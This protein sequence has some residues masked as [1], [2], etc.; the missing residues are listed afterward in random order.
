MSA[1]G[2][3]N[4]YGCRVTG[5]RLGG[6]TTKLRSRHRMSTP[7]HSLVRTGPGTLSS[8]RWCPPSPRPLM[9]VRVSGSSAR[10]AVSAASASMPR[11]RSVDV[12]HDHTRRWPQ[13][14]SVGRVQRPVVVGPL[15]VGVRV[16]EAVA[17]QPAFALASA[18]LSAAARMRVVDRRVLGAGDERDDLET[19]SRSRRWRTPSC[20]RNSPAGGGGPPPFLLDALCALFTHRRDPLA[21]LVG[22]HAAPHRPCRGQ[23]VESALAAFPVLVSWCWGAVLV[24]PPG[25]PSSFMGYHHRH[26]GLLAADSARTARPVSAPDHCSAAVLG[27]PIRERGHECLS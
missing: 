21:Q 25:R 15:G 26:G 3:R 19:R 11:R 2:S 12:E 23:A 10:P 6:A 24:V 22:D 20:R 7:S 16:V 5:C 17:E 13:P 18:A 4:V 8:H 1:T 9:V 27:R 14:D